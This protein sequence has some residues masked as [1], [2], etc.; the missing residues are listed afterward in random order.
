[1]FS[2]SNA[3]KQVKVSCLF[4]SAEY[5]SASFVVVVLTL[6]CLSLHFDVKVYRSMPPMPDI[7]RPSHLWPR[8][9]CPI[10]PV[11][12]VEEVA[13]E[14]EESNDDRTLLT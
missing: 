5:F 7:D 6:T 4:C 2:A 8:A 12:N 11:T 10:A 13:N 3:P 9:H 1:L 14:E